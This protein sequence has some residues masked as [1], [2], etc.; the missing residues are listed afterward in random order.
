MMPW[1]K[2]ECGGEVHS[3]SMILSGLNRDLKELSASGFLGGCSRT[4]GTGLGFLDIALES[5][6]CSVSKDKFNS[7]VLF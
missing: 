3:P 5:S 2:F 6:K 7:A 4:A 1:K